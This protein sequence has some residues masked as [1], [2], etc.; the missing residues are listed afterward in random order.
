MSWAPFYTRTLCTERWRVMLSWRWNEGFG[1]YSE[2]EK[3]TPA[4]GRWQAKACPTYA[5]GWAFLASR[6]TLY[7]RSKRSIRPAVSISFCLPVKTGGQEEQIST[8]RSPLCV[9]WVLNVCPKA[10]ITFTPQSTHKGDIRV[11]I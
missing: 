11:E 3:G 2:T 4:S 1:Y 10:Q 7:F 5:V 8:R 9:D 6:E